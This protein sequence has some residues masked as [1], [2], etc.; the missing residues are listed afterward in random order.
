GFAKR[1]YREKP[2]L[3]KEADLERNVVDAL[4]SVPLKSMRQFY[5]WSLHFADAYTKGL[6][7]KQATWVSK[8]YR[9]HRVIPESIFNKL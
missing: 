9:G 7:G 4:D 3:T 1:D 2:L 5:T 8:K 6:S